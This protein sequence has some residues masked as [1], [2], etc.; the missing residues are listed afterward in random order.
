MELLAEKSKQQMRTKFQEIKNTVNDRFKKLFH[1]LNARVLTKRLEVFDYEDE[2][3]EDGEE[4]DMSTQ[5]LRNQNTQLTDLKQ[6]LERYV[7]TLFS[8]AAD[9][10]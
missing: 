3:V 10:I 8:I 1:K 5:F 7:N 2:F 4:D 9:T 6:P